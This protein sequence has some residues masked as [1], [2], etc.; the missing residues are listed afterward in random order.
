CLFEK[1][2]RKL[3]TVG[4][5]FRKVAAPSLAIGSNKIYRTRILVQAEYLK[6]LAPIDGIGERPAD[7]RILEKRMAYIP[8]NS[9]ASPLVVLMRTKAAIA[10][11]VGDVR[12]HGIAN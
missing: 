2:T 6:Q 12:G 9:E 8:V 7:G 1:L 3:G 10:A 11:D 4:V 5:G